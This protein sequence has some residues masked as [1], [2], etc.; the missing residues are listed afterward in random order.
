M[1]FFGF[2]FFSL[3]FCRK[4]STLVQVQSISASTWQLK[5]QEIKF[6]ANQTH[7]CINQL[8]GAEFNWFLL[9]VHMRCGLV[10]LLEFTKN[11]CTAYA[12][13]FLLRWLLLPLL[14]VFTISSYSFL[15]SSGDCNLFLLSM[16]LNMLGTVC[17]VT[18]NNLTTT[19]KKQ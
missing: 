6:Y 5:S 9:H 8:D 15:F 10:L 14:F 12:Q 19:E 3:Y 13:F 2:G 11:V 17:L 18:N 4:L 16:L 7:Q 1:V